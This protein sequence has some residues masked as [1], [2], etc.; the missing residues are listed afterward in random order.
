MGAGHHGGSVTV[1]R[2]YPVVVKRTGGG[3]GGGGVVVIVT[4]AFT[5]TQPT[6]PGGAPGVGTGVSGVVSSSGNAGLVL[7]HTV[8]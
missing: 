3:G 4:R 2:I 5:G 7:V 6:A 8:P 1:P